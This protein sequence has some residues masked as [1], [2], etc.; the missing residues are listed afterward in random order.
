M[1]AGPFFPKKII[2]TP[3]L[4]GRSKDTDTYRS[5]G[6]MQE[7]G[8]VPITGRVAS[9]NVRVTQSSERQR[10]HLYKQGCVS[11]HSTE[12]NIKRE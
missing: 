6:R 11:E 3:E 1:W 10:L 8:W 5:V 9:E 7:A 4:P 12:R 2:R